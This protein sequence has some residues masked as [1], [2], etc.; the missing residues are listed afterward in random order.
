M[1][2]GP[3]AD[4]N[5][6]QDGE[7]SHPSTTA[8]IVAAAAAVPASPSDVAPSVNHAAGGKGSP[9]S[10]TT[11]G[12]T[13]PSSFAIPREEQESVEDTVPIVRSRCVSCNT[14]VCA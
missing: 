8:A 14:E 13:E 11:P 6:Q 4:T 3:D 5:Q 7:M 1:V 2:S 10:A 12:N 9:T